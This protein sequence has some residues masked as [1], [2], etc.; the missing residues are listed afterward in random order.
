M[1]YHPAM[2]VMGEYL[3]VGLLLL[4]IGVPPACGQDGQ[5]RPQVSGPQL[6]QLIEDGEYSLAESILRENL[7]RQSGGQIS[8]LLGIVLERQFEF[9][10][11]ESHF[12]KAVLARPKEV[13]WRHAL[14]RTLLELDRCTDAIV[15]L[16]DCI[17]TSPSQQT[18]SELYFDK[19]MCALNIGDTETA[20]QSLRRA[21]EGPEPPARTRTK[22]GRLLIDR[23]ESD[24]ALPLLAEAVE[25]DPGDIEARFAYGLALRSLDR[26]KDAI[27]AFEAVIAM[28]P[29]HTGALY[30]LGQCL[31]LTGRT[32][33]GRVAL[34]RFRALSDVQDQIDNH[35]QFLHSNPQDLAARRSLALLLL[36]VGRGDEAVAALRAALLVAPRD[37]ETLNLLA[38]ALELRGQTVAAATAREAAAQAGR[39]GGTP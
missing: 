11:A 39:D 29:S 32:E 22:L 25:D 5:K 9:S 24:L 6:L 8:Y 13:R 33:E 7:E 28:V 35:R 37:V 12:R 36:Q 1:R 19:A 10:E 18:R 2:R 15:E 31:T 4:A 34:E 38:R 16:D 23:G 14:A 21:L 27:V 30:N 3:I 20:E 26:S 17:A